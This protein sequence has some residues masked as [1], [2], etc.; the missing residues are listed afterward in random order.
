[1]HEVHLKRGTGDEATQ[2]RTDKDSGADKNAA[3]AE[4]FA[5]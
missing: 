1:M 5:A 2:A 3:A 4:A